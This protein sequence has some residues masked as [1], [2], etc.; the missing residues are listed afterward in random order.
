MDLNQEYTHDV[1]LRLKGVVWVV[2]AFFIIVGVR[3]FYLQ[4][5]KGDYYRLFSENNSIKQVKILAARGS[6]YDRDGELVVDNRPTFDLVVIPQYITNKRKLAETLASIIDGDP[7]EILKSLDIPRKHPPYKPYVIV[8]DVDFDIVSKVRMQKSPFEKR[9][10]HNLDGVEIEYK[11]TREFPESDIA[12]H[13]L[14]YVREVDKGRLKKLSEKFPG[15][16]ER[17]DLIG[18][19]G[20]E[21]AYDVYIRGE[22]GSREKVVNALGREV[23]FANLSLDLFDEKPIRGGEVFLTLDLNLQRVAKKALEGKTGAAVAIDPETGAV[24]AMYSSPSYDLMKLHT[25][26][27]S[28]YWAQLA[29]DPMRPLYNRAVQGTYPP[30]STYKIITATAALEE[31]V[32][33]RKEKIHCSGG[34]RFGNRVF[35]CWKA[36]GAMD[37]LR[38][39]AWSCDVFFYTMGI[40]LGVD[41]IAKYAKL[42]GLGEKTG[43]ELPGEKRGLIP[44]EEWKLKARKAKWNPGETLSISIGQGYDLTTPLQMALV[45]AEIAN[46]GYKIRPHLVEKIIGPD[47]KPLYEWTLK[48]E[49]IKEISPET[50]ETVRE[51]MLNVVTSGT[52]R[53]LHGLNLDIAGKS[54]TAQVVSKSA[55]RGGREHKAHA[56]FVGFAPFDKPKIA[57]AVLIEHGGGGSSNSGP[58]VGAIIKEYLDPEEEK[59]EE[60]AEE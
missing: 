18:I 52:G 4:I 2:A 41:K 35:G 48:K 47:D 25:K 10:D 13:V 14:G 58:V 59:I 39:I 7:E 17:G 23:S 28:S 8:P 43:I 53:R 49:K 1:D 31:G 15:K 12:S 26:D 9:V 55:N 45:T 30:A 50:I 32:V 19:N 44:T 6:I 29:T 24:L 37:M 51:G 11:Y 40:R 21:E 16:Y 22:K 56:W 46:S 42:F 27:R 36:H 38:G 3:L 54:G 57:V 20:I 5:V 34:L 33:D 60:V